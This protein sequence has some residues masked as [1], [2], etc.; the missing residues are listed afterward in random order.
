M[1]VA[2]AA[3]VVV[4]VEMGFATEPTF[5]HHHVTKYIFFKQCCLAKI[6]TITLNYITLPMISMIDT[7][8]SQFYDIQFN[9]IIGYD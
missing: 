3:V 1:K 9:I 4:L 6:I 8:K 2:I 7:I 5:Q